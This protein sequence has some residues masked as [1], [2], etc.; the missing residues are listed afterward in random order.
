VTIS[1]GT[2]QARELGGLLLSSVQTENSM[3]MLRAAHLR[4]ALAKVNLPLPFWVIH[5][6]GI[7]LIAEPDTIAAR[8]AFSEIQVPRAVRDAHREWIETLG[9]I[10][11]SE[12]VERARAWRLSDDLISVILLRVLGPVY[13]RHLGPGKRPTAMALPLDPEAYQDLS[14]RL[15]KLFSASDRNADGQLLIHLARER[16]RLVTAFEQ[17]D[18]DT[19][20]LLGMMGAEASAA[21]AF[22]MLDLLHV[23]SRPEA[24]DVANFSLDLL[25]SVLETKRAT[26]SQTFSVD[27]YAGLAR[28]GAIDSLV[29]SELAWD[30]D[31][32][33]Q[34]FVENEVFY[35]AREKERDEER[36]LHYIVCD[37]TASMRGQ[38]SVF[39][40]GLALTLVKKL[41]LRGEDVFFRFFDS[42]LYE[43][44]HVRAKR[45]EGSGIDVP[46]V[47]SFKGEHGR[48]YAKV[49]GL[50]EGELVRVAKRE[51]KSPILYILTHA[52]CHVPLGT[53]D[54][55]RE[56]A[57][58]YGI[59]MLPSTGKLDLEY[60]HRLH[61]VQ[62]VDESALDQREA[63]ADRALAIIDDATR[64]SRPS[65][66]PST[67]KP[68]PSGPRAHSSDLERAEAELEDFLRGRP[69][70]DD[71]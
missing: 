16:L 10:A 58:L 43:T 56:V 27:G 46:Y 45:R 11:R 12:I 24:G 25:P 42:R 6:I 65:V 14:A 19:L 34:R 38:R 4:N 67:G 66:A 20:R 15:P 61:T 28:R 13:E 59:F 64:E 17:I 32:F 39:A 29:L 33:E 40:R 57:T 69:R 51:R 21:G 54:R 44:Q 8:S 23:L 1:P 70:A 71:G 53:I 62:I 18:I 5:D 30:I 31:L 47:L 37:A 9:E 3:L 68:R 49:F 26:G 50:L 2:E 22:G 63:R 7:L 60:L 36:N 35:Y 52:E 41:I 55:L 48:N